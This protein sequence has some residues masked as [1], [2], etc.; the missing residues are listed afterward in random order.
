MKIKLQTCNTPIA[1]AR[2]VR[3]YLN[4][5]TKWA[6]YH[7]KTDHIPDLSLTIST[8]HGENIIDVPIAQWLHTRVHN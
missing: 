4:P 8:C 5:G 7:L 3:T 6:K 1:R 2:S